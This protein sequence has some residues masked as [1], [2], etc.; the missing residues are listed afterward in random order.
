[1][2]NRR[3]SEINKLKAKNFPGYVL[4][5]GKIIKEIPWKTIISITYIFNAILRIGYWLNHFKKAQ[6]IL[7]LKPDK[8]PTDVSSYRPISS[9]PIISQILKKI[10]YIIQLIM[11]Y[12]QTTE[13]RHINS[14]SDIKNQPL[15]KSIGLL[16]GRYYMFYF[17]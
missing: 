9:L 1:M 15:N 6:I 16:L 2:S 7:M 17:E 4:I 3:K 12:R 5:G 14:S 8:N 11:I 10:I 13:C